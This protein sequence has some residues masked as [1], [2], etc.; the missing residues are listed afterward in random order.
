MEQQKESIYNQSTNLSFFT[1][2]TANTTELCQSVLPLRI[3]SLAFTFLVVFYLLYVISALCYYGF[4]N[5]LSIGCKGNMWF[6]DEV[7]LKQVL[8]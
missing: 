8:E 3:T 5:N 4:K 1:N 2:V 7:K 6:L